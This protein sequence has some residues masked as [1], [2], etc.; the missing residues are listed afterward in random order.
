MIFYLIQL[1]Y[2]RRSKGV[3]WA[4]F[5]Y[6]EILPKIPFLCIFFKMVGDNE[7][8]KGCE[9]CEVV[10]IHFIISGPPY[11]SYYDNKTNHFYRSKSLT[12]R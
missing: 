9:C 10:I 6:R 5:F 7:T 2:M 8:L 3:L 11:P 12:G 4:L 1:S